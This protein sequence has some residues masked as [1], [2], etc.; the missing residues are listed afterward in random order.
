MQSQ[1][2][3][4]P[5]LTVG[6]HLHRLGHAGLL[7][8]QAGEDGYEVS[9]RYKICRLGLGAEKIVK[10]PCRE[11]WRISAGNKIPHVGL[12]AARRGRLHADG[13][14]T[15]DPDVSTNLPK[16]GII[17][18]VA[19]LPLFPYGNIKFQRRITSE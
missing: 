15:H 6:H 5:A 16:L 13:D 3:R 17:I 12:G 7:L 19:V 11:Q 18:L 4:R 1:R 14:A 2:S 10:G 8:G 9:Y